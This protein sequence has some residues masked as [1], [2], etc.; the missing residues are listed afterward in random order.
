VEELSKKE[1]P[2]LEKDVRQIFKSETIGKKAWNIEKDMKTEGIT[3]ALK[4]LIDTRRGNV[5]IK[6]YY[7]YFLNQTFFSERS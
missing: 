5:G 2:E 7:L 6:S 1:L 3:P 4:T